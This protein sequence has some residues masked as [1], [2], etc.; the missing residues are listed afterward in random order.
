MAYNGSLFALSIWISPLLCYCTLYTQYAHYSSYRHLWSIFASSIWIPPMLCYRTL[1]TSTLTIH[2]IVTYG[3]SISYILLKISSIWTL[4]LVNKYTYIGTNDQGFS[5]ISQAGQ[6]CNKARW[7]QSKEIA[8]A[9]QQSYLPR[10]PRWR[11][12]CFHCRKC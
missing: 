9:R 2:P 6:R 10:Q 7:G 4:I 5:F 11:E 3:L 12:C 1:Y 8:W